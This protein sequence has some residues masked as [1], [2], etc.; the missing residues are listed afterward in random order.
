MKKIRNIIIAL[1]FAVVPMMMQSQETAKEL[2]LKSITL[3]S[4]K[5]S[6]EFLASDWTEG[7][8]TG[9]RGSFL[10]AD[11]IKSM[12][13]VYGIK[14]AG[15]ITYIRPNSAQRRAGMRVQPVNTFFQD[16]SLIKYKGG[17]DHKLQLIKSV[18]KNKNI[19]SFEY[20]TDYSFNISDI[21]QSFDAKV[22]F[23]GYGYID[24]SNAYDDYR[25]IDV[26]GKIVIV[27]TGFPGHR[28]RE[29]ESYKKFSNDENRSGY[30]LSRTKS[31]WAIE[32][33]AVGIIEYNSAYNFQ[34]FWASNYPLRF[35][36]RGYEGDE[37]LTN[38]EYSMRLPGKEIEK[39]LL[40]ITVSNR[41][42]NEIIKGT[43]INFESYEEVAK[44]KMKP[45]SIEI[46]NLTLNL[47]VDVESEIIKA[48]NVIGM[49]EG[50]SLTDV[51]VIGGHY[52]H[53]G[54]SK[55][56]IWNGADDDASGVIGMLTIARAIKAT[57]I[58]PQKTIIFAAWT[59]EE[60]GLLGSKYFVQSYK[61]LEDIKYNLNM[62]MISRNGD[63]DEKGNQ[64]TMKI[65]EGNDLF[66][67]ITAENIEKFKLNLDVIYNPIASGTSRGG[68]DYVPFCSK[69][70]PFFSFNAGFDPNYHH[71]DD[72]TSTLN[73]EKMRSI[74]KLGFLN[75]WD[76]ANN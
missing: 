20:E 50:Q 6:L 39:G 68:S 51:I 21:S 28:D 70:I 42:M 76:I 37:P 44:T 65:T 74:V 59:G 58:K 4:I 27:I 72:E 11:Y 71:Y 64:L 32:H 38:R 14:P 3:E 63:K 1:V 41:V 2:G 53:M 75:I 26:N 7:R 47:K 61:S 8:G 67:E 29:S 12:F 69:Y 57:G 9:E 25:N 33:G 56:Y 23:A 16:F 46:P 52:D 43:K 35:E 10:A 13:K 30:Y 34:D 73:W 36:S 62:D 15:D 19:R 17:D 24:K 49:I 55:G 31:N 66:K 40:R 22:V 45:A 54:M 5:G 60:K 48:R 18:G